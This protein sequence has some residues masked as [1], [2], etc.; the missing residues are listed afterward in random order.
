M[1]TS[2]VRSPLRREAINDETSTHGLFYNNKEIVNGQ[3]PNSGTAKMGSEVV[4][5]PRGTR[6]ELPRKAGGRELS[7]EEMLMAYGELEREMNELR[8][9]IGRKANTGETGMLKAWRELGEIGRAEALC[10]LEIRVARLADANDRGHERR[11]GG[12][13]VIEVAPIRETTLVNATDAPEGRPGAGAQKNAGLEPGQTEI[14]RTRTKSIKKKKFSDT[15]KIK[16]EKKE[17]EAEVPT[18]ENKKVKRNYAKHQ[19]R[20]NLVKRKTT[21]RVSVRHIPKIKW[22]RRRLKLRV[23]ILEK[24]RK[25]PAKTRKRSRV[26]IRPKR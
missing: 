21:S 12:V 14:P 15:Q 22:K 17:I 11:Y 1:D 25:I 8:N 16:L 5:E 6:A 19:L 9:N 4:A 26:E 10:D 20:L 23:V 7:S 2:I 13:R 24:T 18:K 3:N